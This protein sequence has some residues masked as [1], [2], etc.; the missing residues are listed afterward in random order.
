MKIIDVHNHLFPPA[1]ID[2]LEDRPGSPT[3]KRTGPGT[4]IFYYAD[5]PLSHVH[6]AGHF[7][8]AARLE[9]MDRYGIDSQILSLTTPSVEFLP[10]DEGVMW[11]KKV[12]DIFAEY[13]RR[14]K[15][16]FHAFAT[17]PYQKPDGVCEGAGK[18][19]QGPEGERDN[20]LLQYRRQADLF[21]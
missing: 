9:D 18:G 21:A 17:L 19:I 14:I 1:W 15:D 3:L 11:A 10:A 7:D 16:R 12:N 6:K 2:H 8:V 4:M 13:C 20:D 5:R